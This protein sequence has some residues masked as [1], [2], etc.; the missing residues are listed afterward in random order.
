[1]NTKIVHIL[2]IEVAVDV[3]N[4]RL[5]IKIFLYILF[6]PEVLHKLH[7]TVKTL[8]TCAFIPEQFTVQAHSAL[9]GGRGSGGRGRG[10]KKLR[11][12]LQLVYTF[13]TH[14]KTV[15]GPLL[16]ALATAMCS[17]MLTRLQRLA[18][19]AFIICRRI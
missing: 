19:C 6:K 13:K 12:S 14:T 16:A 7:A 1:M 2:H 17:L 10:K 4:C 18:L 11:N 5:L 15:G 8:Q 3:T 9:F